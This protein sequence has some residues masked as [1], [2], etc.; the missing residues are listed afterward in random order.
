MD[1][2]FKGK[3]LN[4]D[5]QTNPKNGWVEGFYYQDLDNGTIKHYIINAPCTWEVDPSTIRIAY[6]QDL[7][8]YENPVT[9][10]EHIKELQKILVQTTIDYIKNH[11]LTDIW[12]VS[13]GVDGLEGNAVECGEWT[14]A[15]D[16]SIHVEGIQE[17]NDK[18]WRVRKEIGSWM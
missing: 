18:E 11:N 4:P 14:P 3:V 10:I 12:S 16:S 13:F 9:T 15:M 1:I 8:K 7:P 5:P 17:E 6:H 2:R